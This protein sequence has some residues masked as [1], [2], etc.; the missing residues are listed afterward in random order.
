MDN[1]W[2]QCY[3]LKPKKV[4]IDKDY[5]T[6]ECFEDNGTGK[7]KQFNPFDLMFTGARPF[8][9]FASI[10]VSNLSSIKNF[11]ERYGILDL[12]VEA[13]QTAKNDLYKLVS[14]FVHTQFE[15]GNISLSTKNINKDKYAN[16]LA[17]LGPSMFEII[18]RRPVAYN[19]LSIYEKTDD[20]IREVN[21]MACLMK[22]YDSQ[23]SENTS[24]CINKLRTLI[25]ES[26]EEISSIEEEAAKSGKLRAI[27]LV[28]VS[29][30]VCEKMRNVEFSTNLNYNSK[31]KKYKTN[32]QYFVPTL[33]SGLYTMFYFHITSGGRIHQCPVCNKFY[34]TSSTACTPECINILSS[35][36]HR[37]KM[38]NNA[39]ALEYE[40]ERKKMFARIN[41]KG[42]K[43]ITKNEFEIWKK[44]AA[45][46][47]DTSKSVEEFRNLLNKS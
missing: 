46:I 22:L 24:K 42:S 15:E 30:L 47:R 29:F 26:E 10:D 36:K 31:I 21:T 2:I 35:R 44:T 7:A 28:M 43:R 9:E 1:A 37:E 34:A 17:S 40:R 13:E 45:Q 14:K 20:F 41:L 23:T 39:V 12:S 8:F 32:A 3:C 18:L 4:N 27:N 11:I 38:A 16:D 6:V 33:L 19:Q 5:I 25:P